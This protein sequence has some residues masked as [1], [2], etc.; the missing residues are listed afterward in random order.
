[1]IDLPY[2]EIL[3]ET[4]KEQVDRPYRMVI[5]LIK[6]LIACDLYV[7]IYVLALNTHIHVFSS[8][9]GYRSFGIDVA[10]FLQYISLWPSLPFLERICLSR[11][12]SSSTSETSI[13]E[14]ARRL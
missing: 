7:D 1:M 8:L 4:D 6:T 13:S 10:G 9:A 12:S 5:R 14:N 3:W 11:T 2:L